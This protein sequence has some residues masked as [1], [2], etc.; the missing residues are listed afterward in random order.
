MDICDYDESSGRWNCLVV[1]LNGDVR[2]LKQHVIR[3]SVQS[4]RVKAGNQEMRFEFLFF[5]TLSD[6]EVIKS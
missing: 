4:G 1:R 5:L 3:G 2:L 6:P